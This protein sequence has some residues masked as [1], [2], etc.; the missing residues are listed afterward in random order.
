[1]RGPIWSIALLLAA[2]R[3]AQTNPPDPDPE[4]QRVEDV[5]PGP[6]AWWQRGGEGCPKGTRKLGASP[7]RGTRMW[8]ERE[9]GT[10]HGPII[11]WYVSGE[12]KTEGAYLDGVQ[13]GEWT[14]WFENGQMRTR[15][16]YEAGATVGTWTSWRADGAKATEVVHEGEGR[17][18]YTQWHPNGKRAREGA[19]VDG[20]EEGVWRFW[21]EDGELTE[22]TE[23]VG[24]VPKR[25]DS[26]GVAACDEYIR[27]YTVCIDEKIPEAAKEQ[28]KKALETSI[29]A[30]KKAAE[31]PEGRDQLARVCAVATEAMEKVCEG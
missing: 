2:C 3:P 22:E 30:W 17:S 12:R 31:T 6:K 5:E 1:M 28:V 24:G 18:M 10:Q 23:F 8:C 21:S 25:D 29:D 11:T 9:D 20:R 15:G 13:T 4:P 26:I 16:S 27:R 14:T 19:Y 7:P